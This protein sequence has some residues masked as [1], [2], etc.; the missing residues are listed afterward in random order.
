[1]T[2]VILVWPGTARHQEQHACENQQPL[3]V[4]AGLSPVAS[5]PAVQ[6]R[7]KRNMAAENPSDILEGKILMTFVNGNAVHET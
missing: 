3:L 7:R 6:Q 5:I 1:M 2:F 4:H